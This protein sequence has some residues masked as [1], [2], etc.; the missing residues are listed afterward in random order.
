MAAG[1]QTLISLEDYFEMEHASETRHEFIDG[2]IRAMPYTT[3]NHQLIL[4]NLMT[5]LGTF[6]MSREEKVLSSDRLLFVKECSA[7][8]YPDITIFPAV[9]EYKPYRGKMTAA[10]NPTVIIEILSESTAHTDRGEKLRC[11]KTIPSLKQYVL[12]SQD[13]KRVEV[14]NRHNGSNEWLYADFV[15]DEQNVK[16]GE[17]TVAMK[18]IY[19]KVTFGAA[20]K[21]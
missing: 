21:A 1:I 12:V 17:C 13:E 19:L 15:K 18:D 14:Y 2:E 5:F 4:T 6:F 7:A 20:K 11:Y 8:Y 10:L 16:I 9:V 3:E